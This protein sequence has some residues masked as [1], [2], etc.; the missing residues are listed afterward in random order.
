M[1]SWTAVD[2]AVTDGH[3]AL[4]GELR[5]MLSQAIH[6]APAALRHAGAKLVDAAGGPEVLRFRDSAARQRRGG[7]HRGQQETSH[8]LFLPKIRC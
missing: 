8:R 4:F 6:D 7:E 3:V 2:D 5:F 1:S